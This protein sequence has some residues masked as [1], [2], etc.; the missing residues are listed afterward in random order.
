MKSLK[1]EIQDKIWGI[2][3]TK[4]GRCLAQVDNT[5]VKMNKYGNCHT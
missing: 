3:N 2:E 5:E 4:M 1:V